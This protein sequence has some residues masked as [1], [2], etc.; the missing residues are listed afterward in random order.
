VK[1]DSDTF[2]YELI[3]TPIPIKEN[4]QRELKEKLNFNKKEI[5]RLEFTFYKK[6]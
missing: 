3:K 4:N 2:F 1:D 6:N 5:K